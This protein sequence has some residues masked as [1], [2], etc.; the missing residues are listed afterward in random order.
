MFYIEGLSASYGAVTTVTASLPL[1]SSGGTSPNISL[2]E[3]LIE[4]NASQ[5]IGLSTDFL[6]LNQQIPQTIINGSPIFQ[7]PLTDALGNKSIDINN[8]LLYRSDGTVV[9][10]DWLQGIFNGFTAT[11]SSTAGGFFHE[12]SRG[13]ILYTYDGN[14]IGT[15]SSDDLIIFVE[16]GTWNIV[17]A[18]ADGSLLLP[19]NLKVTQINTTTDVKSID[20][21][22]RQ[23][24][25]PDGS[26][27]TVDWNL[28]N[29][30]DINGTLSIDWYLRQHFDQMD[31][32]A[33]DVNNRQL[34]ASSAGVTIDWN[35]R[36]ASND[37]GI[38]SINWQSN[39][40][41]DYSGAKSCDW[42]NRK[43][44]K[45]D[46]TTVAL[47]WQTNTPL[48]NSLT[49]AHIFVGNGSNVATDVSLSGEATIANTGAVTLTNSAVIG[50]VLTGFSAGAGTVSGTDTILQ[51]FNKTTGNISALVTGVSSVFSRT[52]AVVATSGDYNTSQ[53]TEVTNLYFTNARAIAA[54]LT[55]YTSG[56]G[57][58][59]SSDSILT[60]VQK[61]NGNDALKELLSNKATDFTTINNTLYPTVQAVNNAITAAVVGLLDYRGAYDASTNLFPA[62]GGSGTAGAIL[63]ADMWICSVAGTLGGVAVSL[64]DLIIAKIDTPLQLSTNWDLIAHDFGYAP[65]QSVSGTTSRISSTGGINPV[66]DIDAAYVG[67]ASITTLGTVSTGTW[68]ATTIGT[69]KG[70][71]NLTSY[72]TG[73]IIYASATNVLSKQ[74]IGSGT[75]LLGISGGIPVW[76]STIVA[77]NIGTENEGTDTTCFP[78]F[79]TA[80]GTQTLPAKTNTAFSFNSLTGSVGA[81]QYVI[82]ANTP[83]GTAFDFRDGTNAA[84]TL[85]YSA[86]GQV[87]ATVVGSVDVEFRNLS[88][89]AAATTDLTLT[90]NTT[91]HY[92]GVGIASSSYSQ[93]GYSAFAAYCLYIYNQLNDIVYATITA[94]KKHIFNTGGGDTAQTRMT[95]E[96]DGVHIYGAT[97][98]MPLVGPTAAN[99]AV[100]SMVTGT[101]GYDINYVSSS[102]KPIWVLG[103][104]IGAV[105]SIGNTS[106]TT[107]SDAAGTAT[108]I[109]VNNSGA[110]ANTII[111]GASALFTATAATRPSIQCSASGTIQINAHTWWNGAATSPYYYL[112]LFINGVVKARVDFINNANYDTE[113][114]I[115]WTGSYTGG[116][117]IKLMLG[118][119]NGTAKATTCT[120]FT[121]NAIFL[122]HNE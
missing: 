61:L 74:A 53:V 108:N 104:R 19:G 39:N 73:D 64:G 87:A 27:K 99:G 15:Q 110:Q 120:D 63:K 107:P 121:I 52:G 40:L 97:A 51:A 17:F 59:S 77:S 4:I 88:G 25:M 44:Y 67:Q 41:Y 78:V 65:V 49:S 31:T 60:A 42:E 18:V 7:F 71:T 69:T 112:A 8:R 13:H 72:T 93:S 46:G 86:F 118:Q 70:G 26:T 84:T 50:K 111:T 76:T 11:V 22:N 68:S 5:V 12:G 79:V 115:G 103:T 21:D 3:S 75:Q 29:L 94:G 23:L 10:L 89:N 62:T 58:I 47:D 2:D 16:D 106:A 83:E 20:V 119:T 38:I 100:Q 114:S 85:G 92:G 14:Q 43:L 1:L 37:N 96:D 57:T 28:M 95:I 54:T 109:V 24:Y 48:I 56:S 30:Y 98:Y 66:I 91:T 101:A 45:S 33:L 36:T 80:S 9:T 55:G 122:G 113:V 117:E 6:K 116:T 90:S 105:Q 82:N 102:A 81:L 34:V 35:N 32:V